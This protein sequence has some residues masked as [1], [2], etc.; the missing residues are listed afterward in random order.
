MISEKEQG[1]LDWIDTQ[2][3]EVWYLTRIAGG[4]ENINAEFIVQSFEEYN[5]FMDRIYKIEGIISL[6]QVF[7]TE[8]IKETYILGP[9]SGVDNP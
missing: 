8:E 6:N 1:V 7:Y 2:K 3:D 4:S 5:K 9:A